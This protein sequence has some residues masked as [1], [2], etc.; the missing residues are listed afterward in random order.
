MT[1]ESQKG[2]ETVL[3]SKGQQHS[4]K[5]QLY[6]TCV[7]AD[8]NLSRLSLNAKSLLENRGIQFGNVTWKLVGV[9][10]FAALLINVIE[11]YITE[12]EKEMWLLQG[13]INF[14]RIKCL[15]VQRLCWGLF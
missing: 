5:T 12:T 15:K 1:A 10:Y 14:L 11:A 8:L 6:P 9:S 3:L 2:Q 7:H 13:P 4:G